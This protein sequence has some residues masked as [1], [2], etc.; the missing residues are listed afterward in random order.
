MKKFYTGSSGPD[1]AARK[2]ALDRLIVEAL[3][4]GSSRQAVLALPFKINIENYDDLFSVEEIRSFKRSG[5]AAIRGVDVHLWA[6]CRNAALPVESPVLVLD[7]SS[8]LVS[9]VQGKADIVIYV[10]WT[11]K[12][13]DKYIS[14]NPDA[15]SIYPPI[16]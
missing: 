12:E 4:I 14:R 9:A 16:V 2:V 3:S 8:D 15:T 1:P 5:R 13:R 6:R 10:P 11:E 7:G